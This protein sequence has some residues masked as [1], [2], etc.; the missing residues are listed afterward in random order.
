MPREIHCRETRVIT[1]SSVFSNLLDTH[2]QRNKTHN[3]LKERNIQF[4]LFSDDTIIQTENPKSARRK[5]RLTRS[6]KS[7]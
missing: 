4:S 5:R 7:V 3:D 2:T 1:E 6:D